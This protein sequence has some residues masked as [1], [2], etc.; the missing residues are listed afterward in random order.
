MLG[1]H[2]MPKKRETEELTSKRYVEFGDE[3]VF[4]R[5]YMPRLGPHR[6]YKCQ[7]FVPH[8]TGDCLSQEATCEK[9]GESGHE[10]KALAVRR[11]YCKSML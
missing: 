4:T 11:S 9:C 2:A 1:H 5:R 7:K 10:K 3:M 8:D 6:C